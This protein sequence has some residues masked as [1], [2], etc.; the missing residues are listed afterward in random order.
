MPSPQTGLWGAPWPC[1][2]QPR[3]TSA[4]PVCSRRGRAGWGRP[5][6]SRAPQ[7][8]P[9]LGLAGPG[10]RQSSAA[11]QSRSSGRQASLQV[12]QRH[13][14]STRCCWRLRARDQGSGGMGTRMGQLG[15]VAASVPVPTS[16]SPACAPLDAS[17]L[18]R[19]GR[20]PAPTSMLVHRLL[21]TPVLEDRGR[22]V[23]TARPTCCLSLPG[24]RWEQA[25]QQQ[26]RQSL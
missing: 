4:P 21:C 10:C 6:A 9:C 26:E 7:P 22:Q 24:P 17:P 20:V 11:A 18:D 2:V 14:C 15:E 3:P 5:L 13:R 16:L 8:R 23:T 12:V 25:Q 19:K 1:R